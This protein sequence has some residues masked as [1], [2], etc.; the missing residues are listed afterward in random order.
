MVAFHQQE[1]EVKSMDISD[2]VLKYGMVGGALGS[3]AG[4]AH[5]KSAAMDLK[6]ELV[7]GCFSRDYKKTL[8]TGLELGLR[9]TRLYKDYKE[10][11]REESMREDGIDFVSVVTPN[12][13][14]YEIAREFLMNGINVVC[15]KPLTI[16]LNEAEE[17]ERLVKEKNLLFCVTY[18]Y[19]G[20]PMVK[21][22]REMIA[23]GDIGEIQIVVAEFTNDWL[24]KAMESKESALNLWRIDPKQSGK[25]NCVADIGSHTENMVSYMTRLEIDSLLAKMDV[26]GENMVLDNNAHIMVKYTNGASGSYWVSQMAVGT[27]H[28]FN[29]RI[30]GNKGSIKWHQYKPEYLEI[31]M[32][33]QPV[34]I[35][36]R[37]N[38]YLYPVEQALSRI[39]SGHPEGYFSAFANI[40]S[41]FADA[42]RAHKEGRD[43]TS[44]S[45]DYPD[46]SSGINSV[47]F[48]ERCL[49]SSQN[50]SVWVKF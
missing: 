34:Q 45:F 22:A 1:R 31:A 15:D 8:S 36:S 29:V 41:A 30:F 18:T 37:G 32:L 10:M 13:S 4:D 42:L 25:S 21:Q 2:R 5:R 44:G 7:A 17:L 50:G 49:E 47:R 14:H 33:G 43:S 27:D 9:P 48:V 24:I 40:Y 20:Y 26:I 23:N 3:F 38:S 39:P 46:I 28:G 19:T 12:N 35:Y 6:C 11:A 16:E